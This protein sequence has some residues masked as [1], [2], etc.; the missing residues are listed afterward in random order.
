MN[1]HVASALLFM[2]TVAALFA[3]ARATPRGARATA[4]RRGRADQRRRRSAC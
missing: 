2:L 1:A 4:N 3:A